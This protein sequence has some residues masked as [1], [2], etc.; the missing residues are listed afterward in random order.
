M[1]NKAQR[2]F[3]DVLTKDLI[4]KGMLIEAGWV[5]L[6][7]AAIPH[8]AP[9]LQIE[10]M[11][12]AFFAGAQHLY[13]S[14][15]MALDPGKEPTDDDLRRMAMIHSELEEFIRQYKINHKMP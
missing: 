5:A 11:R 10:C 13:A 12:E 14:M 7:M 2:N 6:K 15:M 3:V 9:P 8:D 1:A 4:D